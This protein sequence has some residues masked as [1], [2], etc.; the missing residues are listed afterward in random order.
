MADEAATC[1]LAAALSAF[2]RP[3]DVFALSGEL[4]AGKTV[5]ARAFLRALSVA[6]DVPSPTFTL[7]QTY[8]TDAGAVY[9]FDM[10]RLEHAE[11]AFELSVEEAFSDAVSLV[12]WPDRLGALLPAGRLDI[13]FAYGASETRR[14]ITLT[15][16]GGWPERLEHAEL[17]A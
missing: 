12:E 11:D 10:Y 3:G 14:R 15:C 9:H 17:A 2:A 13:A 6:E 16:H 4:G 7:V 5:F 1:R 8:D